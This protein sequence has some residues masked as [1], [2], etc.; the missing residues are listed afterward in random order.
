M[1]TYVIL[2]A[3]LILLILGGEMLVR[4]ASRL[5]S[6]AGISPLM[7]G[8]TV[9]AFGTSAPELAVSLGATWR[10]SADLAMGN[11]VGSNI[12]NVLLILGLSALVAPLI[13]QSRLVRIDVPLMVGSAFLFWGLALDLVIS[14]IDAL[15]LFILLLGYLGYMIV[16]ARREATEASAE[17]SDSANEPGKSRGSIAL[18][19]ILIIV[20]L[21]LLILGARWVVNGAS[22]IAR[23]FGVSELVIGLTIVAGGT[24]LPELAASIMAAMRGQRDIAVGNIVGSN[25]FNVHVILGLSALFAPA[26]VTVAP[27][28]LYMDVPVMAFVA[29]ACLPIFFSGH[30]IDRWEGFLFLAFYAFYTIDL[31]AHASGHPT[32]AI[33]QWSLIRYGLPLTLVTVAVAV[34][35]R[36]HAGSKRGV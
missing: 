33:Y 29:V 9:V 36:W 14:R 19:F 17:V 24:S 32:L 8:L 4:G 31:L 23:S 28:L 21:G 18:Q 26:E 34:W 15:I 3:G 6:L 16:S 13:V 10:G 35:R 5:A 1:L 25:L 30:R 22:A 2:I 11:V 12:F 27:G 20:G 7:I